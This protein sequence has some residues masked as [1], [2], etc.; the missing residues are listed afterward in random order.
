MHNPSFRTAMARPEKP[1]ADRRTVYVKLRV[2][3][4]ER[5]TLHTLADASGGTLSD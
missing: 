5:E 2:T 1:E 4:A 3:P